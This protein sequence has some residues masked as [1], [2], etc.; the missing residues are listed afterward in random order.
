MRNSKGQL[1][2]VRGLATFTK[3]A[4]WL[5][6][7]VLVST[8]YSCSSGKALPAAKSGVSVSVNP[9]NG[10]YSVSSADQDWSFQGSVG[11]PV[12]DIKMTSG[13]DSLGAYE[14]VSFVWKADNLYEGAIR[15]Y[16]DNPVVVFSL[17][18]M[19][20]AGHI[21]AVFPSFTK[22]PKT[23]HY[24]FK[25]ID[26]AP[27]VFK[28]V[29]TSTPWLFFNK[30]D[31]AF[32]MSPASDFMVAK[33]VGNGTDSIASGLNPQLSNL[34]SGFTHKTIMAFADH[35]HSAWSRWGDALMKMYGKKRPGNES[36]TILKYYGYWTDNGAAYYYN[37]V[38]SKGYAGTLRAVKS[39]FRREGIPMRY[40]QLDSW[41]YE[42]SIYD[43]NGKPDAGHKNKSLPAIGKWNRY[44]GMLTYRADRY[45]FPHGLKGFHES[46]GLP[47]VVHN[48]WIDPHSP[49]RK[50][51][52]ID[53]YAAVDPAF[54]D[55]IASFIKS[56]GVVVYEQDWLDRIYEHTPQMASDLS[57]GNAFTDNMAEACKRNGIDVQYCMPTPRYFMQGVKFDNLTTIRTSP[58]RFEPAKWEHFIYVS[59]LAYSVGIWP[60]C[61]V[62]KS[63]E[64]GNMIV[65]TLSAGAVGTGDSL[66]TED[67][68]NILKACRT[69]GVLVKP[70]VSLI[71]MDVDY[72]NRAEKADEPMLAWTYTKQNNVKTDYVLAFTPE[73]TA[74][75]NVAFTTAELGMKGDAVVYDAIT[76]AMKLV[77]PEQKF[78]GMIGSLGYTYYIVAPVTP[79]GIAFLGDEGKIV[80]TGRERIQE[81]ASSPDRLTVDVAFAKGESAVTLHGY[82][83]KPFQASAG[84]LNL[85][86]VANTFT[87]V[88]PAP[89][90]GNEVSVVLRE[91]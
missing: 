56:A 53:G 87:L 69:D 26:F 91:K 6:C 49:Y 37:Y 85:D 44:G 14:Q 45:L 84:K 79:V 57:V 32:I 86:P 33:M 43:P 50:E 5:C 80:S 24:S 17:K 66:G 1:K 47:F 36:D 7:A 10:D 19:N 28:L 58:D 61:D 59:Q 35:I 77:G 34:P 76:G 62:F 31:Q 4:M 60:W 13:S 40:M 30:R 12:K 73:G 11:Q 3:A 39:Q 52:K 18:T 88:V 42:K 64:T 9:G 55:H 20:K 25:D 67:K 65:S 2:S 38:R 75:K 54:W 16:N 83:E 89:V 63:R 74:Q 72:I 71:P 70:D 81:L 90:R 8:N 27:P 48:R 68:A 22:F 82:Y 23:F 51:Y 78:T 46:M 41:W 21:D 15:R 29:Q